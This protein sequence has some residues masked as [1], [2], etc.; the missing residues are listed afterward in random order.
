M[1]RRLSMN[2]RIHWKA[3]FFVWTFF[4]P[5]KLKHAEMRA[6]FFCY[7]FFSLPLSLSW[8]FQKFTPFIQLCVVLRPV[9]VSD[10]TAESVFKV[11][12]HMHLMPVMFH[13]KYFSP[14]IPLFRHIRCFLLLFICNQFFAGL[15]WTPATNCAQIKTHRPVTGYCICNFKLIY[16][17]L[18]YLSCNWL[19]VGVAF[20]I[21]WCNENHPSCAV[22]I[23]GIQTTIKMHSRSFFFVPF[24]F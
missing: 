12:S 19:L 11:F 22:S 10:G 16:R 24:S 9:C 15:E 14:F 7:Q 4:P 1:A 2:K 17:L 8:T 23:A 18:S 21:P 13:K 5:K 20:N 3:S 6:Q